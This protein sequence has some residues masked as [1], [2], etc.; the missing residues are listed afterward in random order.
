VNVFERIRSACADVAG[1]AR[2]VRIDEEALSALAGRL[3]ADPPPPALLDPAHH[4]RGDDDSTLAY[5]VCLD[6]VNFGSGWF[7][8]LVK[9][10]G[11]SGYFTIATALKERFE[12]GGPLEAGDLISIQTRDCVRIFRQEEAGPEI[13]ELM[14]LFRR[15][16]ND[17]GAFLL[18]RCGGRFDGLIR[19]AGGRAER[20]VAELERMPFYRDVAQYEGREVPFYK[21]AQLT[22]ADLSAAFR[23]RG[24]GHFED[25]DQLTLFA[26]NLVP[27]VLRCEGVLD[28]DPA[29]ARCIDAGRRLESGSPEEV[30]IRALAVHAVERLAERLRAA[31][32]P[33]TAGQLDFAL[34][35]RGQR[36]E[37]K[38]RPRHRTRCVY[39]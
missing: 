34:W 11:L 7:P 12:T 24:P 13:R 37:L 10:P 36:P 38:A 28:Y 1:R 6:A 19:N 22:A 2:R 15:A 8:A 39:Y 14:D 31:G 21:R 5:V 27:H 23:G 9:R 25:L 20:L 29:L 35:N 3:Q 32:R 16:W 4:H 33:V 30:E 18:E 26:D 17:L